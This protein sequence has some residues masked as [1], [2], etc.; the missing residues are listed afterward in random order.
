MALGK[1]ALLD[2][3]AIAVMQETFA[4]DGTRTGEKLVRSV[5]AD[6]A[7]RLPRLKHEPRHSTSSAGPH[8]SM[9]MEAAA[10]ASS[11]SMGPPRA[12]A[13]HSPMLE[14]SSA[15]AQPGEQ[16]RVYTSNP[17]V[18]PLP[19]EVEPNETVPSNDPSRFASGFV[20]SPAPPPPG[21]QYLDNCEVNVPRHH[22]YSVSSWR[23]P[24][25]PAGLPQQGPPGPM[26]PPQH[27][28]QYSYYPSAPTPSTASTPYTAH[29]PSEAVPY[30]SSG[31][32]AWRR[33]NGYGY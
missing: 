14:L 31:M 28:H 12:P 4:H 22:A 11:S 16:P 1:K 23:P 30:P 27:I 21:G 9:A 18:Y 20:S 25:P 29:T 8:A 10:S 7:T 33:G 15:Q 24:G 32:G 6:L 2:G 13:P 26:Q 19:V 5:G 17:A 3:T